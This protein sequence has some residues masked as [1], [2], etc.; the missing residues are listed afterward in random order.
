MRVL[1]DMEDLTNAMSNKA[2][3]KESDVLP[4]KF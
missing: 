3:Q 2:T 4:T 1:K